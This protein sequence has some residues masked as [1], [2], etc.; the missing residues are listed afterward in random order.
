MAHF[1]TQASYA[2]P[3]PNYNLLMESLLLPLFPLEVVLF[4]HQALPLHIFED[5]YKEMIGDCLDKQCEFG[6]VLLKNNAIA[7]I[8]CTAEITKVLCKHEDGRM[9]IETAGRR[10]FEVLFL[11]EKKSYLRAAGQ[12]FGDEESS[13]DPETVQQAMEVHARVLELLFPDSQERSGYQVDPNAQQ[14]S[15]LLA[16]P[17]P[18]ELDFKQTLLAVRSENDRLE[19]LAEYM[20]KLIVRLKTINKVRAKAGANG[21][22]R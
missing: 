22:G 11:D 14:I 1:N 3:F 6:V 7:S 20:E 10:R 18:M 21:Q 19:R 17:L 9:D 12:F 2:N 15:F 4:P 16:G 5:R 13:A 8:G